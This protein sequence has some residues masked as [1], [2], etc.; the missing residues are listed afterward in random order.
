MLSEVGL[1]FNFFIYVAPL[2]YRCNE[3]QT[4]RFDLTASLLIGIFYLY[5]RCNEAMA[6]P[7]PCDR[8]SFE[9][10]I[11]ARSNFRLPF[12]PGRT[13][14]VTFSMWDA[15]RRRQT[16]FPGPQI[17]RDRLAEGRK[18]EKERSIRRSCFLSN[19]PFMLTDRER[20]RQR[21]YIS[22]SS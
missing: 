8:E 13:A 5:L 11:A 10:R 16:G 6:C 3:Q 15:F 2:H 7:S 14:A 18:E 9:K 22:V 17:D 20:E 4:H 1:Q 21:P 19:E 12:P